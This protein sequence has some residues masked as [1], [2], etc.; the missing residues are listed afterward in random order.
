MAK[1]PNASGANNRART[2]PTTKFPRRS[3]KLFKLLQASPL[4]ILRERSER[5][6]LA[7]RSRASV[8]ILTKN[9]GRKFS[10]SRE[11]QILLASG[12]PD[13]EAQAAPPRL[14]AR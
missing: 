4:R 10:L 7:V 6:R 14:T 11:F 9:A 12:Q 3:V 13:Q 5:S 8:D 1:M 2:T